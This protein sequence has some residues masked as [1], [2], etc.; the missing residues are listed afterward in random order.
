[1][2]IILKNKASILYETDDQELRNISNAFYKAWR[3]ELSL[4]NWVEWAEYNDEE[5][6]NAAKANYYLKN[7]LKFKSLSREDT[8]FF[9]TD[10]R[11]TLK[12]A[13]KKVTQTGA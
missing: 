3:Y 9:M 2:T 5:L 6:K 4:G 8:M 13:Y 10:I 7:C 11:Y 12:E 1:M